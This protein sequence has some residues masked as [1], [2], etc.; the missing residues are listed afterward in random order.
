MADYEYLN[1]TIAQQHPYKAFGYIILHTV[2]ADGSHI[3]A[4]WPQ[5]RKWWNMTTKGSMT[6]MSLDA[7]SNPPNASLPDV[8]AGDVADSTYLSLSYGTASYDIVGETHLWC[9]SDDNNNGILPD[10]EKWFLASGQ[11]VNL[12]VGTKLFM[13]QG[14]LTI[15]GIEKSRPTQIHAKN[16]EISVTA[17][18]DSFGMNFV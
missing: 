6:N 10:V 12:P 7:N 4:D 3:V 8:K 11:T 1:G 9:V 5:N 17:N 13:C 2:F 14:N 15:N 16:N 18:E